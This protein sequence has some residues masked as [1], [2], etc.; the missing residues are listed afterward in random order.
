MVEV[1]AKVIRFKAVTDKK[2]CES[3]FILSLMK[4]ASKQKL[5]KMNTYILF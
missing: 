3:Q 2:K 4:M 5:R 1:L